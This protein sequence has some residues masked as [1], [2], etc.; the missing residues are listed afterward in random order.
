M[1]LYLTMAKTLFNTLTDINTRPGPFEFYTA[2]ALWA[3]EHTSEKMLEFHLNDAIDLSSRNKAFIS[4]SV[5]WIVSHFGVGPGT[6][7]IDLGCGPGFYAALFAE[8]QA[9]VTGVDFSKKSIEFARSAATEK[10]L[11]IDYRQANYLEFETDKQFDLITMIFCDFCALSPKQRAVMLNKMF[12]WLKPGGKVLLDV[13]ALPLFDNKSEDASYEVNQLNGF[14]SADDYFGFV[15]T[16]KYE[17]EKVTLDK[18]TIVAKE[19]TQTIYNW[20]QYFSKDS[21]RSEFA[22]HGFEIEAFYSDVAGSAFSAESNEM[23][24]VARKRLC[25]PE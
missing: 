8:N 7:V 17:Q 5:D 19:R 4:R 3:D 25:S 20:L 24:V 1:G 22:A 15:N 10:N 14:W 6:S 21:I 16:F 2:E 12:V 11:N 13:Y 9:D 23:A 18:Y